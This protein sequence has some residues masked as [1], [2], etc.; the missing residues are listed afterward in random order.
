MTRLS[1][2]LLVL[3]IA[4]SSGDKSDDSGQSA[5]GAQCSLGSDCTIS[6]FCFF[7]FQSDNEPESGSCIALPAECE[8]PTSCDDCPELQD[9][10]CPESFTTGCSDSDPEANP[11]FS[12]N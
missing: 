1:T 12:C 11:I 2:L 8:G 3:L 5:S 9:E 10:A 4:C 7:D 6:E